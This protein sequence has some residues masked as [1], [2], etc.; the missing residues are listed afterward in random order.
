MDYYPRGTY[1]YGSDPSLNSR[2]H[3]PQDYFSPSWYDYTGLTADQ[4]IGIP[5]DRMPCHP[6]DLTESFKEWDHCL[7]TGRDYV[8]EF[9]LRKHDDAWRWYVHF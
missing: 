4:S 5:M 2:A 7:T 9:R 3:A 1:R 8:A 6:D